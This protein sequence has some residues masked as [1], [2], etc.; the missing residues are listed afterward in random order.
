M[1]YAY[2]TLFGCGNFLN[3][4]VIYVM[5]RSHKIRSSISSFLIF[6]L[7]LT[8]VVFH[9]AVPLIRIHPH[10]CKASVLIELTCAAAIFG[11]L[12]AIAWD[13]KRNVLQPFKSLVRPHLKAYLLLVACIWIYAF[14]TST[15]FVFSVRSHLQE[16]CWRENNGTENCRKYTSCHSPTDWKSQLSKTLYF[17]MAF[18][19]PLLYMVVTYTKVAVSLWKRSKTGTI[20]GAVAKYKA[21]S[22]RLMII[23]VLVFAVCWGLNFITDLLRVYGVLDNISLESDVL[24]RI[25]CLI[26]QASSSCLNPAIYAFFSPEFRRNCVKY[27]CCCF[28]CCVSLH[29][30]YY[31]NANRVQPVQCKTG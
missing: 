15:P 5:F 18:V 4:L 27:C 13:R 28:S 1:Y 3:L 9:L 7:S 10:W 17:I 19:A 29:R 12:A 23:A 25:W 21:R 2:I 24:L 8:H 30:R 11:G 6:Y 14:T 16:I 26:A 31:Y 20:H 22:I